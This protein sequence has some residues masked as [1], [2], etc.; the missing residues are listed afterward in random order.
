MTDKSLNSMRMV[1]LVAIVLLFAL[2]AILYFKTGRFDFTT[3]VGAGLCA[4]ILI[5]TGGKRSAQGKP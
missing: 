5:V 2:T 3:F 1:L 4:V